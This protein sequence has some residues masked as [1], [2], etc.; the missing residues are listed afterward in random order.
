ML[1]S[2]GLPQ[3]SDSSVLL[4]VSSKEQRRKAIMAKK[5]VI[6]LIGDSLPDF[7]AE[8]KTKKS[9]EEQRKLVE[10]TSANFGDSWF[11]LPDAAYGSW[12]DESLTPWA[13]K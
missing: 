5:D 2:F 6:M 1:N 10:K 4:D 13:E 12:T 8:F 9:A 3:V 11:I 7:A